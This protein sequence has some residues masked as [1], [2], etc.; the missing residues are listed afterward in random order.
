MNFSSIPPVVT[1]PGLSPSEANSA[2]AAD[3]LQPGTS[4]VRLMGIA[5]IIG[6]A[7]EIWW[8]LPGDAF[9]VS[10]EGGVYPD[11]REA[12]F[13][14][15]TPG[16]RLINRG[17][18]YSCDWSDAHDIIRQKRWLRV[19][20]ILKAC[21]VCPSGLL[22]PAQ[23]KYPAEH[24]KVADALCSPEALA[25]I[26]KLNG[27]EYSEG[28]TAAMPYKLANALQPA[29]DKVVRI[30]DKHRA[31]SALDKNVAR[32]QEALRGANVILHGDRPEPAVEVVPEEVPEPEVKIEKTVSRGRKPAPRE[33]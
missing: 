30:S 13:R 28:A 31:Q 24:M 18:V 32:W 33:G 2:P 4:I 16:A 6:E 1:I 8:A 12:V 17:G 21:G 3:D 11:L 25:E 10:A 15:D 22:S 20:P 5:A 9:T 27:V 29:L 7:R 14:L 26:A 23:W 19:D